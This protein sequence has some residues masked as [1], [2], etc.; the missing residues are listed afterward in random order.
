VE[1]V[2]DFAGFNLITEFDNFCAQP[3]LERPIRFIL[4]GAEES[5]KKHCMNLKKKNRI[6]C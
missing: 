6:A 5:K 4:G 1:A 2:E 3:S